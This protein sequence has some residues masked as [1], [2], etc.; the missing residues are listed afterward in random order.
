MVDDNN[1]SGLKTELLTKTLELCDKIDKDYE[2]IIKKTDASLEEVLKECKKCANYIN[3]KKTDLILLHD[4]IKS[5]PA[6]TWSEIIGETIKH[7]N[8]IVKLLIQ[9]RKIIQKSTC[10]Q[11]K[12]TL[13][14]KFHAYFHLE[15]KLKEWAADKVLDFEDVDWRNPI[16]FYCTKNCFKQSSDYQSYKR[17]KT[18]NAKQEKLETT[19]QT[20]NIQ[21]EYT[22][23][24][25]CFQEIKPQAKYYYHTTKNDNHKFCSN[26]CYTEYYGE[27]CNQCLKKTLDYQS[28]KEYPDLVYCVECYNK[29][30]QEEKE[31]KEKWTRYCRYCDDKLEEGNIFDFC[32]KESCT[33]EASREWARENGIEEGDIN[34]NASLSRERERESKPPNNEINQLKQTI[35][36]LENNPQNSPQWQADLAAKKKRLA[37]LEKQ[38][39]NNPSRLSSNHSNQ[40]NT[41]PNS[42]YLTLYLLGGIAGLG[43][44]GLIAYLIIKAKKG[45]RE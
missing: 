26:K 10:Y 39:Q 30:E 37:E 2:K 20:E 42:S 17:K 32:D 13:P 36:Q 11:C 38:T 25:Q 6:N 12:K 9:T 22:P 15:K 41:K 33:Q 35:Q 19:N 16:S 1:E 8:K 4:Q 21:K 14:N 28:D 43:L 29:K 40:T 24:Q 7:E 34:S 45:E 27:I 3:N 18:K 44:I 23:C 31:W 5:K